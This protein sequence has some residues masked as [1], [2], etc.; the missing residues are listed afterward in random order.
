MS[1]PA[2]SVPGPFDAERW[3]LDPDL[4]FLNHGSFG[5]CPRVVLEEQTRLRAELERSPIQFLHRELEPRLDRA[6]Q[7]LA[8]LIGARAEDLV[9][10][11]NATTG[12]NAVLQSL[13]L[14][15]GDEL[16]VTDHEY[17]AC[18]NALD[19]VAERRGATVVVAVLP[20]PIA[21]PEEVLEILLDRTTERTKLLLI[22]AITSPTGLVMPLADVV[23]AMNERGIDTLVDGAHAPGQLPLDLETLG[24]AYFTG[25]CHKWLCTPKGSALLW[26]RRD[27][28]EGIRPTVLSHGARAWRLRTDR[29]RFQVEFDWTGTDDPT[30][31]LCI[32]TAV[33]FLQS[34][35]P[36]GLDGL[37][38]KNRAMVLGGRSVLCE[39]LEVEAPCPDS[40][41]GSLA[42]VA[43]PPSDEELIPGILVDPLQMQLYEEDRIEVPIQRWNS[44]EGRWLRISAQHYNHEAQYRYLAD[45]LRRRGLGG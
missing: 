41:I 40:M 9:F 14:D 24:A 12:V 11:R 16:L 8:E 20:M 38:T 45:A 33:E 19:F 36:N 30:P 28:Q 25:N 32:P 10:V 34:L 6:K 7:V 3:A 13:P 21:G 17:G 1:V 15:P 23:A 26:V 43:L 5:A 37:R 29:S 22:D 4:C 42:A 18:R 2:R 27:K 44:P 35:D 31:A 39:A